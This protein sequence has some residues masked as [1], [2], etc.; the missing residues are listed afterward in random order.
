VT[1][2]V[3]HTQLDGGSVT[4]LGTLTCVGAY[5]GNYLLSERTASLRHKQT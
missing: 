2:F 3:G 1:T 5:D 4:N